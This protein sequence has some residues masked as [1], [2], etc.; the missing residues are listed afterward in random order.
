MVGFAASR[1]TGDPPDGDQRPAKSDRPR[2]VIIGE[3]VR[4]QRTQRATARRALWRGSRASGCEQMRALALEAQ[5]TQSCALLA[6]FRI[7]T[8]DPQSPTGR[9]ALWR[10]SRASGCERWRLRVKTNQ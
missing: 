7:A 6:L 2:L 5:Q 9:R 3:T 8:S 10:G 4:D 1:L